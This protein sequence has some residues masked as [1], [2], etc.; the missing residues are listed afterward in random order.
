MDCPI[1]LFTDDAKIYQSV[2]CETDYLQLQRDITTLH[3]WSQTWLLNFNISKYHLL[4][5]GPTH[6]YGGYYINGS[7]I[8]PTESVKDLGIIVDPSLKFHIHAPAE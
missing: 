7:V 5:L 3:R 2:R 1:L 6:C 8:T 4:H